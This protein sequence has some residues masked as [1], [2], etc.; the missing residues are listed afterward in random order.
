MQYVRKNLALYLTNRSNAFVIA[1]AILLIAGVV[2]VVIGLIIGI[3]TG[4]PLPVEVSEGFRYNSAI[5][6]AVPSFLISFGVL[7]ANRGLSSAL[8][9]GSTRGHFWAGTAVGFVITSLVTTA[10]ALVLLTVETTTGYGVGVRYLAVRGL[11]DGRPAVVA[12]AVFFLCLTSLFAGMSFGGVYRAFGTLW[13]AVA[14]IGVVVVIL[15]LMAVIVAW[16]AAWLRLF[17]ELGGWSAPLVFLAAAAVGA[18]ASRTVTRFAT[19]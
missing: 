16:P 6:W 19:V 11:D 7:S 17:S 14:V 5:F 3:R 12:A 15:A 2:V 8:A 1:P 10:V 4:L 18:A 9:F 13:T